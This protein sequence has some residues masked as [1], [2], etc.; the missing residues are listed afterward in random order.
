[1][2]II[3]K[4]RLLRRVCKMEMKGRTDKF[5]ANYKFRPYLNTYFSLSAYFY[6]HEIAYNVHVY[7]NN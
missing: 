3:P 7:M 1:M 2:S 6:L 4:K 5:R